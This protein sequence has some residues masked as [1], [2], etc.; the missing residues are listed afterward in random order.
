MAKA[1]DWPVRGY[2][3]TDLPI[4]ARVEHNGVNITQAAIS[5]ITCKVRRYSRATGAAS[6]TGTP[7]VTVSSAVYDTLQTD[8][9]W[10]ADATGYNFSFAVPASAFPAEDEYTIVFSFT[11]SSGSV[12]RLKCRGPMI[13][14]DGAVD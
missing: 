10:K 12:F 8:D 11:P 5:S 1:Q 14:L 9:R 3:Q 13:S 4:L 6:D 7:T 2:E